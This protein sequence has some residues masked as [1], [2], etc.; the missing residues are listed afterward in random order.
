VP[1][2]PGA[3]SAAATPPPAAPGAQAGG[4]DASSSDGSELSRALEARTTGQF[5]GKPITIQVRDVDVTDVLRLISEASGFNIVVGSDVH[6]RIT[7]SLVDVPWDQA[8][9]VVLRSLKLGAERNNNLL[10]V[11]TLDAM[12]QE[13]EQELRAKRAA[14]AAAPTVTRIFPISYADPSDLV[15]VLNKFGSSKGQ[16][17]ASGVA[18]GGG[19]LSQIVVDR[20]TNS[21]IVQDIVENVTKIEK[22]IRLL[23]TATPQILIEAK[24]VEASEEGSKT[25]GGSLGVGSSATA[26]N[27]FFGSFNSG[28]PIDPLIGSP[29]V[30]QSGSAVTSGGGGQ[31]GFSPTVSFIPGVARLNATLSLTEAESQLKV[32]SAPK[33]VV[34]NKQTATITQSTPVGIPQTSA[35]AGVGVVTSLQIQQANLTMTAVPTVTNDGGIQ[36][37]LNL[38]RDVPLAIA[39]GQQLAVANRSMQTQVLVESGSTLVI[40]G[41]Y[42]TQT[43]HGESGFPFLRKIPILGFLFGTNSDDTNRD[44]LFFFITPRILNARDAGLSG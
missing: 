1:P 36:M 18:S 25:L 23:D 11:V 30:L 44:E 31:F 16:A 4:P 9:D 15:G 13:K 19:P 22:L 6:G 3:E 21:I 24:I 10:R 20:R 27:Q 40:G 5:T 32:I 17:G 29:G 2:P 8:L 33:L 39:G 35:V 14:L 37:T 41:V 12:T 26:S 42:T 28:N 38:E 43:T 7:M 34:L